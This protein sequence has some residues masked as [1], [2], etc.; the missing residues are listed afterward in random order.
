MNVE[1]VVVGHE[2][3]RTKNCCLEI[4]PFQ[5]NGAIL[6][7]KNTVRQLL[8]QHKRNIDKGDFQVPVLQHDQQMPHF[9]LLLQCHHCLLLS[10][11][12]EIEKRQMNKK[13]RQG[14]LFTTEVRKIHHFNIH[15]VKWEPHLEYF[16]YLFYYIAGRCSTLRIITASSFNC[17]ICI[18]F[19]RMLFDNIQINYQ[20]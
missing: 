14:S 16:S 11:I 7:K 8:F 10:P 4:T 2:K 19:F 9:H 3:K 17:C 1:H 6:L 15:F 20:Q 18:F 13:T 5:E 12:P